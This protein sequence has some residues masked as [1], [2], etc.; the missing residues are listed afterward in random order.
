MNTL[1]KVRALENGKGVQYLLDSAYMIFNNP[2]Y[3]VDSHYNLISASDGPMEIRAWSELVTM[4]T[5][6]LQAKEYMAKAGIYDIVAGTF[7]VVAKLKKP[8]YLEK[9]EERRYGV[10][11]GQIVNKNKDSVGELVMY[12]YYSDFDAEGLDAFEALVEKIESEIYDYEYF[13]NLPPGFFEDTIHKLLD[14][15]V[16]NTVVHHSQARMIRM[17]YEKY[18]YVAVVYANHHS[19]LES[20]QRSRLEYFRSLLNLKY[21]DRPFIYAIFTDHI[22]MLL[23]SEC[24]DFD[25]ALPLGPEYS[26]FEHND[27]YVGVGGSFEDIYEFGIHYDQALA[28]LKKGLEADAARRIFLFGG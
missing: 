21:G 27:L 4:G 22:V 1:G 6:S 15:T 14:R 17:C 5:F 24:G 9:S 20:V 16:R 12:E 26:F 25:E 18:L 7:D 13:I 10:M 8:I 23:G 11:T 3:M 19:M 2:V 28:A